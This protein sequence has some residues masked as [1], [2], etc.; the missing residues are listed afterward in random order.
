MELEFIDRADELEKLSQLLRMPQPRRRVITVDSPAGMGKTRLLFE[1]CRKLIEDADR[2]SQEWQIVRLD[3]RTDFQ[4]SSTESGVPYQSER[5]VLEEIARQICRDTRWGLISDRIQDAS[6]QDMVL[7]QQAARVPMEDSVRQALLQ[8]VVRVDPDILAAINDIIVAAF[9][10][11]L[12]HSANGPLRSVEDLIDFVQSRCHAPGQRSIPQHVLVVLDGVDAVANAGLR[13]WIV[14]DLAY[15]LAVHDGL[16]RAFER[17]AVILSGRFVLEDVAPSKRNHDF[18]EIVLR[19]FANKTV[20]VED[21]IW[22]FGD[23]KFNAQRHLVNRLARKLCQVCG[24]HPKVIKDTA[25]ELYAGP[26]AFAGLAMEPQGPDY[27]YAQPHVLQALRDRREIA[28]GQV[29]DGVSERDRRLLE[30]LSIFRIFSLVTL[31]FLGRKI[32][33]SEVYRYYDCIEGSARTLYGD[34]KSTRLIGNDGFRDSFD[35]DRFSLNLLAAHMHNQDPDMFRLLHEWAVELYTDWILG[36]FSDDPTVPLQPDRNYQRAS[37]REW[38]YHRLHLAPC[39]SE[40]D[41]A[42]ALGREIATKLAAFLQAIVPPPGWTAAEQRLCI[43]EDVECDEQIDHLIW[44]V[45]LE[46]KGRR[47]VIWHKILQA[48]GIRRST[49]RH[50]A[51]DSSSI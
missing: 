23:T 20:Y 35:S 37:V 19:S 30:L 18:Q 10:Q 51:Q 17:L 49:R 1:T 16:H 5:D 26:G 41:E 22:Q 28:L 3:F 6:P 2:T 12:L 24:G 42:E 32:Q 46:D 39:C 40:F 31:E 47:D 9:D 27:W 36:K 14:N 34:L 25:A 15:R 7:I 21:L 29:L 13:R 33:E 11:A 50:L 38:L 43:Q 48:F 44:E 4:R 8:L 45:T